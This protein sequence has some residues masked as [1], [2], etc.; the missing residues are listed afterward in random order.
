[1]RNIRTLLP[2]TSAHN[3]FSLP[4]FHIK[5]VVDDAQHFL[6]LT[7]MLIIGRIF[8]TMRL[9]AFQLL[10]QLSECCV[11][12]CRC[13]TPMLIIMTS[14]SSLVGV[15]IFFFFLCCRLEL[16]QI[17]MKTLS[18]GSLTYTNDRIFH[19]TSINKSGKLSILL[20]SMVPALNAK[21]NRRI[22]RH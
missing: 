20:H 16:I 21:K 8:F 3:R 17:H 9:Y 4:P 10:L 13:Y 1:M 11:E 7:L 19:K 12:I 22:K 18:W 2:S 5:K 6:F 15:F 14:L